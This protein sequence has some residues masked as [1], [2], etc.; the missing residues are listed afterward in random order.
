MNAI[1]RE[2]YAELGRIRQLMPSDAEVRDKYRRE[3]ALYKEAVVDGDGTTQ[4]GSIIRHHKAR[5]DALALYAV[6][7]GISLEV[8]KCKI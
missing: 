5:R 6:E 4:S 7:V 3:D 8:S 1:E 2:T